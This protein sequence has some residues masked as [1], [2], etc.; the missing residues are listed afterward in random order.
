[1]SVQ[2]AGRPKS[3]LS[4]LTDKGSPEPTIEE[5]IEQPS[6]LEQ[7]I[8][9]EEQIRLKIKYKCLSS[10]NCK[11]T[12]IRDR[13]LLASV[14]RV[15]TMLGN[16]RFLTIEITD[17]RALYKSSYHIYSDLP[18]KLKDFSETETNRSYHLS[19]SRS[20]AHKAAGSQSL[21]Q[22][23]PTMNQSKRTGTT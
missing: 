13:S 18:F 17:S 23:K 20:V 12:L 4:T 22:R 2:S 14:V 8:Q 9:Y 21:P 10:F 15:V 16:N 6:V 3:S 5:I 19:S 11:S 7:E 1:M